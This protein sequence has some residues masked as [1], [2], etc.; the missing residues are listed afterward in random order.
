ML[1]GFGILPNFAAAMVN[2]AE[3]WSCLPRP[4]G[5]QKIHLYGERTLSIKK[6]RTPSSP[7]FYL[8][9]L[10][11]LERNI[12]KILRDTESPNERNDNDSQCYKAYY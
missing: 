10:I 11:D 7:L 8:N 6:R 1:G 12:I 2:V 3:G 5:F 4:L 9:N